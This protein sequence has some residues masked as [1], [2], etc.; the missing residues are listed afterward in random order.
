MAGKSTY[1][2]N[3]LLNWLKG[4]AMGSSPTALYVGLFTADPTDAGSLTNEVT[5]TIRTAG[6]VAATFG[7][8]STSSGTGSMSNSAAVGFGS[9]AGVPSG[10]VT[11]FGI[12]DAVSAGNMLYSAAL[13]TPRT[14][15]LGADV[16]FAIGALAIGES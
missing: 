3:K 6:R 12:F 7:N 4:T 16:S 5:T 11:H 2:Q 1:L 13:D 9:A 15:T 10:A 8:I 14:I